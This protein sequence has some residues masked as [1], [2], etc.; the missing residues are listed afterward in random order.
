MMKK[1]FYSLITFLIAV[2]SSQATAYQQVI[3][4]TENAA[5][6]Q[7]LD[8]GKVAGQTTKLVRNALKL[9]KVDGEFQVFPWARSYQI[10][11]EQPNTLIYSL[12]K[13]PEREDKFHWIGELLTFEFAFITVKSA[14]I[15]P[16]DSVAQSKSL[17]IA[18]M[19]DDY[20][21][22]LLEQ[23]GFEE[24]RDFQ[25]FSSLPQMLA[26]LYAGKVDTFIADLKQ[27]KIMAQSLNY[28]PEQLTSVYAIP[29]QS[30]PVYLAANKQTPIE[31][32]EKLRASLA[33]VTRQFPPSEIS[34]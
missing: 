18:V 34:N 31:L 32:V 20:T 2:V 23:F 22:H 25:L 28:D 12:V 19:R 13:T 6:L 1:R 10:A 11:L 33:I 7:F 21:H 3:V 15:K 26:L 16:F 9:A 5:P 24:N 27:L 4:V 8:D 30:M 14:D 29:H 17:K